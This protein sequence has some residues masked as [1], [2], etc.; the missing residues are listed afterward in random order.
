ML[1][2]VKAALQLTMAEPS[3]K[4]AVALYPKKQTA[5]LFPVLGISFSNIWWSLP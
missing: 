3:G 5:R 4:G 1:T 2:E